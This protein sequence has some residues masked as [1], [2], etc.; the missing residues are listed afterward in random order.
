[1][2]DLFELRAHRVIAIRNAGRLGWIRE[3]GTRARVL[4]SVERSLLP[5]RER[6]DDIEDP[7]DPELLD[8]ILGWAWNLTDVQR[9]LSEAYR[10]SLPSR[11][12][13]RAILA[14]WIAGRSLAAIASEAALQIDDLLA[15]HTKVITYQLQVAAEQG[16]ALLAKFTE[17]DGQPMSRAVF[18]F[19]EHLRFGVPTTAARIL[20]GVVRHRR[21]AVALGLT[22][23]LG[24]AAPEEH[25]AV[26]E[27]AQILLADAE[28]WRGILGRLV[29]ENTVEDLG[30]GRA[31]THHSE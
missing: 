6:W 4:E 11:D 26:I 1:M 7:T 10:E 15:I 23:E 12:E 21:A 17:M 31:G 3:T 30:A 28:R 18:D 24:D 9:A 20:A 16:V 14:A 22:P 8:A 2:R 27:Q 25:E 5:A 29:I 19:P 13:F